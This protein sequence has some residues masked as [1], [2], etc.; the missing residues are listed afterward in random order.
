[1][2]ISD[3]DILFGKP[4]DPDLNAN[5]TYLIISSSI[6][7]IVLAILAVILRFISRWV[8]RVPLM[9]DD[10]LILAALVSQHPLTEYVHADIV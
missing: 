6:P 4:E 9:L 3:T 5:K 8:I 10:W 2:A 1:M 7:L